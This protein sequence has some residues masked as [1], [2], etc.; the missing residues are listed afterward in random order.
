M[1]TIEYLL[2][3]MSEECIEISHDIHKSL[4]FGL[5]DTYNGDKTNTQHIVQEL[6]DLMG[7]IEL[8]AEEGVDFLEPQKRKIIEEKKKRVREFM[9][10]SVKRGTL[11]QGGCEC[12]R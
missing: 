12:D 5:D 11:K 4:R 3:C 9:K 1:N 6:C 2:I 7:V 10:Y 8:L